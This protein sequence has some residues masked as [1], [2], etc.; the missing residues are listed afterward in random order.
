[1]AAYCP[2]RLPLRGFPRARKLGP[3]SLNPDIR[4]FRCLRP[5]TKSSTRAKGPDG[6]HDDAGPGHEGSDEP[7]DG[8]LQQDDVRAEV[9]ALLLMYRSRSY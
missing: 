7:H 6:R 2:G 5:R 1:M 8:E 3:Y 9:N 4:A